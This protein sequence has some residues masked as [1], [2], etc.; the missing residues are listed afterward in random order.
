LRI[1]EKVGEKETT[2]IP[3]AAAAS[4]PVEPG[5]ESFQSRDGEGK[6]IAESKKP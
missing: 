6:R 3:Q 4:E 2:L 1:A 5:R